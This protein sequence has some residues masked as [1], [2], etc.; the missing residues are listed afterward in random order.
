[1]PS[2]Q[3]AAGLK[4]IE[5]IQ[6]G[7]LTRGKCSS[8]IFYFNDNEVALVCFAIVYFCDFRADSRIDVKA[9]RTV[10]GFFFRRGATLLRSKR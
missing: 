3:V 10:A 5:E 6:R 1:M 9:C 7:P 2:G 8:F 4:S